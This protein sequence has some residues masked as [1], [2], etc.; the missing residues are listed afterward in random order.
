MICCHLGQ[1]RSGSFLAPR[2]V[3]I[4][5]NTVRRLPPLTLADNTDLCETSPAELPY[6][7]ASHW[8]GLPLCWPRTSQ[9]SVAGGDLLV[10]LSQLSQSVALHDMHVDGLYEHMHTAVVTF[11]ALARGRAAPATC[12]PSIL[13]C[14]ATKVDSL[15][16][17][18]SLVLIADSLEC[19]SGPQMT[20]YICACSAMC[21]ATVPLRL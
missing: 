14:T 4:Q 15:R 2:E 6:E 18:Q 11:F 13:D 12:T 8:P 9:E 16:I 1:V 21:A 7:C 3:S 17:P 20:N 5:T 19:Q 10:S